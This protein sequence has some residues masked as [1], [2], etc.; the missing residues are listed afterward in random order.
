MTACPAAAITGRKTSLGRTKQLSKVPRV[1]RL[2]P[3]M[4]RLVL[5]TMTTNASLLG[6]NQAAVCTLARQYATASSG[7]SI[8][9]DGAAHSR[10]RMTLNSD[11]DF[12]IECRTSN[13]CRAGFEVDD[14]IGGR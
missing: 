8:R 13:E 2:W 6:S 10:T 4:R 7:V 11:G 3:R 9:I 14:L 12:I 1:T 5:S